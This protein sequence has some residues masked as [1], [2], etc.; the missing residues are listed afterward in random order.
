MDITVELD[1]LCPNC[2]HYMHRVILP[3]S[4]ESADIL[5]L[6]PE[7]YE[8]GGDPVEQNTCLII[9]MDISF[10]VLECNKF[11]RKDNKGVGDI[12]PRLSNLT[13]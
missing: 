6:D 4:P 2:E 9:G 8:S 10:D 5:G 1:S 11:K 12:W 13:I 7:D 3:T